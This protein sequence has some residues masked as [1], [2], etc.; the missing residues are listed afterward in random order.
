MN[1]DFIVQNRRRIRGKGVG[2]VRQLRPRIGDGVVGFGQVGFGF[3][4]GVGYWVEKERNTAISDQLPS[5]RNQI[6]GMALV[7]H[8]RQLR[9]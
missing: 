3:N 9:P 4:R 1:D 8:A 5:E 7:I 6:K 2:R